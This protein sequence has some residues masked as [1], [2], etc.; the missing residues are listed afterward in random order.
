MARSISA[1]SGRFDASAVG[2]LAEAGRHGD[3]VALFRKS[4]PSHAY[5]FDAFVVREMVELRACGLEEEARALYDSRIN[6]FM[7]K[8][9]LDRLPEYNGWMNSVH[10]GGLEEEARDM[11]NRLTASDAVGRAVRDSLYSRQVRVYVAE[12]AEREAA[13]RDNDLVTLMRRFADDEEN[14]RCVAR[15]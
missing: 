9:S 11:F 5:V 7:V 2:A 3:A 8:F 1:P 13:E 10:A 14:R 6:F 15:L 4:L 12:G